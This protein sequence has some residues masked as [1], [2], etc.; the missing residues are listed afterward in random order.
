M[1]DPGA[2]ASCAETQ[3]PP[4]GLAPAPGDPLRGPYYRWLFF[5]AGP[6]EAAVTNRALGFQVPAGRERMMGYGRYDDVMKT[7]EAA[8][9]GREYLLGPR[10]SAADLYLGSHLG[11]GMQFGTIEKRPVF[12]QYWQRL[13]GRPAAVRAAR[14]DDE[15]AAPR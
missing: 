1:D 8:L 3:G 4:A 15:L 9:T 12:E 2:C 5:A 11:F 13:S 7:V 10:F 6:L 14:M